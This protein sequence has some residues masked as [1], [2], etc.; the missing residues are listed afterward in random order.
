MT[1]S[2]L[3]VISIGA[4][5]VTYKTC[6]HCGATPTREEIQKCIDRWCRSEPPCD[7]CGK[8]FYLTYANIVHTTS[9]GEKV[10]HIGSATTEGGIRLS[11]SPVG[12]YVTAHFKCLLKAFPKLASRTESRL[13]DRYP[14]MFEE[15]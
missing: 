12:I 10:W 8:R 2:E 11:D 7:F 15:D 13:R 9:G 6:D 14:K 5:R 4:T 3:T 1:D